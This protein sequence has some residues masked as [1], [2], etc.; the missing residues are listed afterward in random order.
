MD[1]TDKEF[2]EEWQ[3]LHTW[4]KE[5]RLLGAEIYA[6]GTG[7]RHVR[8]PGKT[9]FRIIHESRRW[10]VGAGLASRWFDY[11][12]DALEYA[13]LILRGAGG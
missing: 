11:I 4:G 7:E 6:I 10:C 1:K 5:W 8:L 3:K 9:Y 13:S 12:D 2:Q